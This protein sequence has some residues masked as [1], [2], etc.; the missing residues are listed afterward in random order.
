[1]GSSAGSDL[2][3]FVLPYSLVPQLCLLSSKLAILHIRVLHTIDDSHL[4][5]QGYFSNEFREQ[6]FLHLCLPSFS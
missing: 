2:H 3:V 5:L 4:F 1:M 6:M